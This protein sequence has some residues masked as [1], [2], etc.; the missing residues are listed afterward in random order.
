MLAIERV[1]LAL[2]VLNSKDWLEH[3]ASTGK[4]Q[5]KNKGTFMLSGS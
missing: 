3:H 2:I 5:Y 4:P 1:K